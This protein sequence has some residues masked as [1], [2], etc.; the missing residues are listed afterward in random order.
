[1]TEL[2]GDRIEL[3]GLRVL[4]H[5]GVP[6][7]ERAKAQPLEIDL[8]VGLDLTDA[9]RDDDLAC[10]IDYGALCD[11]VCACVAD[12]PSVLIEHLA[13]RVAEAA[14]G[15]DARASWVSVAVRKMRPPVPHDL[16][17]AGVR[18]TRRR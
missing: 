3:R 6:E 10:T 7:D 5:C 11:A 17:T 13:Q 9:C 8:D 18:V 4:G 12:R 15:L 2:T 1:M 14:L 16:A